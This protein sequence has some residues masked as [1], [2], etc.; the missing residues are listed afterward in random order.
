MVWAGSKQEMS[1][2]LANVKEFSTIKQ[3]LAHNY[4]LIRV[5]TDMKVKSL[6]CKML[7][8]LLV[9]LQRHKLMLKV[10]DDGYVFVR[11]ELDVKSLRKI[12]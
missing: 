12:D 1:Y 4:S 11:R 6:D 10:E 3:V 8:A 9:D 2:M 7:S 5:R